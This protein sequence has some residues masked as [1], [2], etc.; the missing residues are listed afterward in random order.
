M[1]FSGSGDSTTFGTRLPDDLFAKCQSD[2][3]DIVFTSDSAGTQRLPMELVSIDTTNKKA[4]IWV[5]IPLTAGTDATVYVRYQSNAGTL[6]QPA[7]TD[8]YGSKAVWNG[9]NGVGGSGN[10]LKLV[11]HD[12]VTD[13]TGNYTLS[14]GASGYRPWAPTT[15]LGPGQRMR[16]RH[17]NYRPERQSPGPDQRLHRAALEL[18]YFR[19]RRHAADLAVARH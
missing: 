4:V 9:A 18:L 5:A 12:L 2:G 1:F 17:A 6:T 8:T 14:G 13:S 3:G 10:L 19:G 15:Y 11:S 7:A 16:R